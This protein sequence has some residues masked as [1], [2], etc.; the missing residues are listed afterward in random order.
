MVGTPGVTR[1]RVT[2]AL[3]VWKWA[4]GAPGVTRTGGAFR[5]RQARIRQL[6][7]GLLGGLGSSGRGVGLGRRE[8]E[9]RMG[10]PS[11]FSRT[12]SITRLESGGGL[13]CVAF[14]EPC[15]PSA[16]TTKKTGW[17]VGARHE[18]LQAKMGLL[19]ILAVFSVRFLA[20]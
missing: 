6:L 1:G 12:G 14:C 3:S 11:C 16:T 15:A 7:L 9:L 4:N 2:S 8:M 18:R 17:R 10:W 5:V 19:T 20:T 13:E